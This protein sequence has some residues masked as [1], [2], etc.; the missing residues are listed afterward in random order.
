MTHTVIF[1]ASLVNRAVLN[2]LYCT[3]DRVFNLANIF[4]QT[5]P[6]ILDTVNVWTHLGVYI[7]VECLLQA[8]YP[9]VT[10]QTHAK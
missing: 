1:F 4:V 8:I 6:L 3:G 9:E 5:E 2:S 7:P 10:W